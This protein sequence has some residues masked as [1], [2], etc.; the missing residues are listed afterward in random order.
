MV[1]TVLINYFSVHRYEVVI[2]V[3]SNKTK[4]VGLQCVN[5]EIIQNNKNKIFEYS[6]IRKIK[7][8]EFRNSSMPL[9]KNAR[10]AC[11]RFLWCFKN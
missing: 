7:H 9:P 4:C 8:N 1:K 6:F 10:R 2:A 3:H 5:T 11:D